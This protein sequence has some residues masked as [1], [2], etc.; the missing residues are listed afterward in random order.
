MRRNKNSIPKTTEIFGRVIQT[1]I[2]NEKM[3]KLDL[4]GQADFINNAVYLSDSSEDN[5]FPLDEL[6][7]TYIHEILHFILNFGE[8]DKIFEEK[9]IDI[10]HFIDVVASGIYQALLK[11]PKY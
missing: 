8:Y 6:K 2:D 5:K 7:I 10:E 1:I 3:D 11:Y 9:G 4:I